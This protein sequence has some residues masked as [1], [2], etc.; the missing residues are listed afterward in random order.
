MALDGCRSART[1][2]SKLYYN[3]GL[4]FSKGGRY[5]EAITAFETS[6]KLGQGQFEKAKSPLE[7]ARSNE[8]IQSAKGR[9][10]ATE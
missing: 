9:G 4:A 6:L 3:M 10:K 2:Q 8:A 7:I 5:R 1:I